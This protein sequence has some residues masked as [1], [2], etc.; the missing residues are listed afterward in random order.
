MFQEY[1]L[2]YCLKLLPPTP[3]TTIHF[4]IIILVAIDNQG[5]CLIFIYSEEEV[6]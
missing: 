2:I 6:V 3:P 1:L 5:S 4:S